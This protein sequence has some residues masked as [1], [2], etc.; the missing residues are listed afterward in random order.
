MSKIAKVT[1]VTAF[2]SPNARALVALMS[3]AIRFTS[4]VA[5]IIDVPSPPESYGEITRGIE[6]ITA[7]FID[8]ARSGTR[9]TSA[10]DVERDFLE[11]LTNAQTGGFDFTELGKVLTYRTERDRA[12]SHQAHYLR[13]SGAKAGETANEI[14]K[15]L[16]DPMAVI[17]IRETV[18][19]DIVSDAAQASNKTLAAVTLDL[20]IREQGTKGAAAGLDVMAA[21]RGL[22][23]LAQVG[24]DPADLT[25]NDL[26]M[27]A[28]LAMFDAYPAPLAGISHDLIDIRIGAKLVR[29]DLQAATLFEE[30]VTEMS[31]G[32]MLPRCVLVAGSEAALIAAQRDIDQRL[33]LVGHS[34]ADG[35]SGGRTLAE[36]RRSYIG[37]GRDTTVTTTESGRTFTTS[38]TDGR[39]LA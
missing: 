15:W 28:A 14:R 23:L 26:C 22:M 10:D 3:Q 19:S 27:A 17:T 20:A 9:K 5:P 24:I 7:H 33:S 16:A 1:S 2:D 34:F 12:R 39:T 36:A 31:G 29:V 4:E 37:S 6:N 13:V 21:G 8:E 18:G 30:A 38:D 32:A 35:G 11:V 25:V